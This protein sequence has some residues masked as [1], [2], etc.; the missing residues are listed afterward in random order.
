V[1]RVPFKSPRRQETWE[2]IPFGKLRQ[3]AALVGMTNF[4]FDGKHPLRLPE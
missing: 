2:Q 1:Q 4:Y 3:A